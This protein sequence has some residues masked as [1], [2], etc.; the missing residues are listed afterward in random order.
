MTSGRV[1]GNVEIHTYLSL[2]TQSQVR[3]GKT[4]ERTL[5]GDWERNTSLLRPPD[6]LPPRDHLLCRVSHIFPRADLGILGHIEK[7]EFCI[8]TLVTAELECFSNTQT[9]TSHNDN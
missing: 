3:A 2:K 1:K 8:M 4:S 6:L 7:L 9:L 5:P